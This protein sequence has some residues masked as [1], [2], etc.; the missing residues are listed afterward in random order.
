M[1]TRALAFVALLLLPLPI[2]SAQ[3]RCVS[4]PGPTH[5]SAERARLAELRSYGYLYP[6]EVA[7]LRILE[8]R[9]TWAARV[10]AG[11]GWFYDGPDSCVLYISASNEPV[12]GTRVYLPA[13]LADREETATDSG[14]QATVTDGPA[15]IRSGPGQQYPRLALCEHGHSLTVWP[16]AQNGWLPASCYGANGWIHDSLVQFDDAP[17]QPALAPA[18]VA[19]ASRPA[20]GQQA[21]VIDGPARIRSGP[22]LQYPRLALCEHGHSLTVWPPAQN[23]WLPASC[24]GAN[25]WIHESLVAISE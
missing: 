22:G 18:P 20:G 14:Q 10:G 16:P 15:R 4:N 8:S 23:G 2:V 24:Y 21:T 12:L 17:T 11:N 13:S 5:S 7:E 9:P 1:K 3:E 19:D 25:G 6:Y